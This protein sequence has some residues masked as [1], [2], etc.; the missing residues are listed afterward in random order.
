M[1][2]N[3]SHNQTRL[4]EI[5][6]TNNM[7]HWRSMWLNLFNPLQPQTSITD[8]LVNPSCKQALLKPPSTLFESLNDRLYKGIISQ[9]ELK[10]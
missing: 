8:E 5:R 7:W 4:I 10:G 9:A 6:F 3:K 1:H 2:D